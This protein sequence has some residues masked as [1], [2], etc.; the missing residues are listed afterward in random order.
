MNSPTPEPAP[1]RIDFVSDIVCPWCAIGKARFEQALEKFEHADEVQWQWRSFELD[2]NRAATTDQDYVTLLSQKYGTSRT[3]A[4]G[5]IDRMTESGAAEGIEF[6]FAIARPGNTFDAH[7]LIHLGAARGIQHLCQRG[8]DAGVIG[9]VKL[10]AVKAFCPQSFA[11]FFLFAGRKD[12]PTATAQ[13][14][15]GGK[16]DTGR[17][18]SDQDGTFRHQKGPHVGG[19]SW[20]A[21]AGLAIS[22][23]VDQQEIGHPA[24]GT[25]VNRAHLD[26]TLAVVFDDFH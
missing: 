22:L 19:L 10:R 2:P 26:P 5:M 6:N 9:V 13:A 17:T 11:V 23:A 7:R 4:Q 12:P 21:T 24:F 14:I 1:L 20:I 18:A 8:A 16:A 15:R 25:T 3:E